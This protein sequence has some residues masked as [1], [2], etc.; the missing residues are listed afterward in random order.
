MI[1]K[2]NKELLK[3]TLKEAE[4]KSKIAVLASLSRPDMPLVRYRRWLLHERLPYEKAVVGRGELFQLPTIVEGVCLRLFYPVNLNDPIR[5][6]D[7]P[8]LSLGVYPLEA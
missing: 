1:F 6:I 8:Q 5:L 4:E 3:D 7:V 2:D